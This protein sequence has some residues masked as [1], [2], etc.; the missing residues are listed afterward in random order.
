M[1]AAEEVA[2][3]PDRW[4]GQWV[5]EH[6]GVRL[7]TD[8]RSPRP[9]EQL[10]GLALRRN[11][12]RAHLLVSHVL[13]KHVPTEPGRVLDAATAL[14]VLVAG[15]LGAAPALVLG[16]AETATG[17]G[18][19]VAIALGADC[20]HSTR[21]SVPGV[22]VAV[23]FAEAHSH[24]R[25]HLVLPQDPALLLRP[26]SLVL[27]DDE[28]STGDTAIG[29][30]A[31]LHRLQPRRR[32]V[33]A[34]LVDVR[35]P[36]DRERLRRFAA[37]IGARVDVVAL[38]SGAIE[39]PHDLPAR[40]AQL[41]G[42][43]GRRPA[44]LIADAAEPG[45]CARWPDGVRDGGR[46]GFTPADGRAAAAAARAVGA[47]LAPELTGGR[48]LVLGVEELMYVPTLIAAELVGTG[49]T[50]SRNVLVSSTTRSPVHALDEPGYAVRTALAFG[51]H[52]DPADG[53]GMRFAYN[54]SA[55]ADTAPFT[56][57]VLV[58]DD[59]ADTPALHGAGGLLAVLAATGATVHRVVV[60]SYRPVSRR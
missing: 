55:T 28:L 15:E 57:I 11:P 21:R 14:G 56:D 5:S 20:L 43:D 38:G 44:P 53:P 23:R 30:I 50:A 59:V 47:E 31:A 9:L 3:R 1:T 34:T 58:L 4:D 35:G 22:P 46:H 41:L 32:Y 51:A 39:L 33:I 25:D 36:A 27:V 16:Y 17:L 12:R 7:R 54:V 45:A 19:G 8:A 24:A 48:V 49:P 18:H 10:V 29:T 6:L 40:A 37:G 2:S 52:D 26:G 60:P 13:G 42:G